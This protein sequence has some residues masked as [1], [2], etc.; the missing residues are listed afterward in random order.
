V[1]APF[2]SEEIAVEVTAALASV[3][4]LGRYRK[5]TGEIMVRVPRGASTAALPQ[6]A[7]GYPVKYLASELTGA[8]VQQARDEVVVIG[9]DPDARFTIGY[10]PEI[11]KVVVSGYFPDP[12]G[13][14]A[15][16]RREGCRT[17]RCCSL[18]V[19]RRRMAGGQR[20]IQCNC[21]DDPGPVGRFPP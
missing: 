1:G 4:M 6:M 20:R 21:S 2:P 17:R 14:A 18:R 15:G 13:N 19:D 5:A 16:G 12:D 10:D 11:D 3:E 9:R 8:E 7:A